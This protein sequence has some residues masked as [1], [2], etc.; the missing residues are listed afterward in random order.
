MRKS[1]WLL[2]VCGFV[3]ALKAQEDANLKLGPMDV[4]LSAG[5][6]TTYND[7]INVSQLNPKSDVIISPSVN[8]NAITRLN[9]DVMLRV[10]AGMSY[11][12][13]IWHT[14]A[15]S[16]APILS[17]DSNTG[18]DF[19]VTVARNFRFKFYDYV[20]YQ[21]D[22]IDA[23][24]ISNTLNYGRFI[25]RGGVD[26]MWDMND[27]SLMVGFY[28]ENYWSTTSAYD[29]LNRSTQGIP[30]EVDFQIGADTTVG[31]KS[32]TTFNSYDQSVMNN[33]TLTSLGPFI[34]SKLNDAFEVSAFAGLQLG[35]FASGGSNL[36]TTDDLFTYILSMDVTHHINRAI[37]QTLTLDRSVELGTLSNFIELWSIRHEAFWSV[38]NN[39]SIGTTL[40]AEF[41][42]ESG[43]VFV[44]DYNRYGAGCA[45]GYQFSRHLNGSLNYNFTRKDSQLAGQ[46]YDQNAVSISLVYQF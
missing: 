20:S 27:A 41:A 12:Q 17:P 13:H 45:L 15:D 38:V 28:Q 26:G 19:Q 4:S 5:L 6:S 8:V 25:N 2:A 23:G 11:D 33:G 43:G 36:D 46:S 24:S 9:E 18:F 32:R 10:G 22:P 14:E 21:Q 42:D 16:D 30:A 7:N 34:K 35:Y 29:Y 40:F 39:V 37:R 44:D 3:P 31:A 1:C